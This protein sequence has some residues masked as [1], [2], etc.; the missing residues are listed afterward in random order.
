MRAQGEG[1]DFYLK[2]FI[3]IYLVS[4]AE[5]MLFS[6]YS[7][8]YP[9]SRCRIAWPSPIVWFVKQEWVAAAT[10]QWPLGGARAPRLSAVES[11]PGLAPP[12]FHRAFGGYKAPPSC[13][14]A[15]GQKGALGVGRSTLS[16]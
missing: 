6:E 1:N 12:A 2:Y 13:L 10:S 9:C 4:V 14:G 8:S 11:L 5:T 3:G 7:A 15:D 16:V